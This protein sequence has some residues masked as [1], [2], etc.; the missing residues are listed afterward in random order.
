MAS[1]TRRNEFGQAPGDGKG[2]DICHAVVHGATKSQTRLNDWTTSTMF[3]KSQTLG[4]ICYIIMQGLEPKFQ[5]TSFKY[6]GKSV[7]LNDI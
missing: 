4:I 5:Q 1:L 3:L 2:Q 7:S 6:L